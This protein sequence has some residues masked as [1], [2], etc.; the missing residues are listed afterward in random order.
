MFGGFF[1]KINMKIYLKNNLFIH[2]FVAE[3]KGTGHVE[4][5][6]NEFSGR[7]LPINHVKVGQFYTH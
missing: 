6:I 1:L 7:K 4:Q 2:L 3:Q 5:R